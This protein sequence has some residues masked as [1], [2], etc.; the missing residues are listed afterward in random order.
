MYSKKELLALALPQLPKNRSS[1]VFRAKSIDYIV[2]S[3]LAM[4]GKL[5]IV[6]IFDREAV[7]NGFSLPVAVVFHT[8]SEYITLLRK[9]GERVWKNSRIRHALHL[10]PRYQSEQPVVCYN[11][12]DEKRIRS[13]FPERVRYD[14]ES[15]DVLTLISRYQTDLLDVRNRARKKKRAAQVDCAMKIVPKLPKVFD[16]W[17]DRQPLKKSRYVYY[18]RFG[19]KKAMCFCTHCKKDFVMETKLPTHNQSGVC[20]SCG[21]GVIYKAEGI[22]RKVSDKVYTAIVQ[23]LRNGEY[24]LRFFHVY[25]E[26][27]EHY[28]NHKTTFH[29]D[30]RLFFTAD[31]TITGQ[32]KHGHSSFTGRYGW[33]PTKDTITGENITWSVCLG[34][35]MYTE[36]VW[37]RDAWLYPYN[38]HS[39]LEKLGL[40]FGIQSFLRGKPVNVTTTL[41]QSIRYPFGHLLKE[42]GMQKLVDDLYV[43]GKDL[44]CAKRTGKLH[45]C[46]G[47]PKEFLPL[48]A[49]QDW[50]IDDINWLAT[51][52]KQP[53]PDELS[54]VRKMELQYDSLNVVLRY[55]TFH[56]IIKYITVQNR[57]LKKQIKAHK[58]KQYQPGERRLPYTTTVN[59][60]LGIWKDYLQM[61]ERIGRDIRKNKWLFPK[62]LQ[63]QHDIVQQLV[64]V[65]MNKKADRQI[66]AMYEPLRHQYY[67][68]KGRYLIRPPRNFKEFME[69]GNYLGHCVA[70][71]QYY[72]KHIA[73]T[74]LIFF[75]REVENPETPFYTVELNPSTMHV[76]QCQGQNHCNATPEL[77]AFVADWKENCKGN[78]D[79]RAA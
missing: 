56:K 43:Q 3:K 34:M 23:R 10:Y 69:E 16:N 75:L 1:A 51:A 8:K 18:R 39:M 48:V 47:I 29:E 46:L 44:A 37:F 77:N 72:N 30:G 64:K 50:K 66:Q 32:Y 65:E 28:R 12:M 2:R 14:W 33:Y 19:K 54:K 13:F 36:N 59:L 78:V 79:A 63:E 20:Q 4:R 55:T 42:R 7:Q 67:Y 45:Q 73:G 6:A 9:D 17:L 60:R 35:Y 26:F 21:S 57:L 5:L 52:A 68:E 53:T 25:R 62:D 74:S 61:A 70:S 11:R 27:G 31:G 58:G 22:S 15:D 76:L 40:N 49:E 38:V 41:L 71:N 24:L